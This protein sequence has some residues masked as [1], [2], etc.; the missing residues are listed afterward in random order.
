MLRYVVI[1]LL[2][3][4]TY[5]LVPFTMPS[6]AYGEYTLFAAIVVA[7][8]GMLWRSRMQP[9]STTYTSWYLALFA[10]MGP[11]AAGILADS[12]LYAPSDA[13]VTREQQS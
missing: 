4:L 7:M 3:G 2:C 9:Q 11:F 8:I 1:S 6:T 10:G 13:D 12:A 5:A